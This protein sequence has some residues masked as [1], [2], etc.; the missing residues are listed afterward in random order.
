MRGRAMGTRYQIGSRA[1][2]AA[3]VQMR[4]MRTTFIRPR[5]PPCGL[6]MFSSQYPWLHRAWAT[7]MARLLHP[8]NEN[9]VRWGL[10]SALHRLRSRTLQQLWR[11]RA[12]LNVADQK[13]KKVRDPPQACP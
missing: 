11:V 6:A 3:F 5:M 10:A 1:C 2:R 4:S 12:L 8:T 9:R 13:A 7:R